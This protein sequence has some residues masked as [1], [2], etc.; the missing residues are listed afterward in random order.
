MLS[1]KVKCIPIFQGVGASG[2]KAKHGGYM[3]NFNGLSWEEGNIIYEGGKVGI[4]YM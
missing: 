3:N 1:I 4:K 2:M